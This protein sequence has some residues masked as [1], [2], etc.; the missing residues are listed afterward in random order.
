MPLLLSRDDVA[1]VLT[2][3]MC[4]AAVEG[5]F[6]A[7]ARGE[8]IMPQRAAMK[9][10]DHGGLFLGMP[11]YLAGGQEALGVKVVTVYPDNPQRHDLATTLGTLMLCDPATGAVS[12]IMDAGYLTAVRTGAASGVATRYLARQDARSCVVF[13]AGVQ[14]RQQLVAVHHV[15]P[16]EQVQVIDTS[17]DAAAA[18]ARDLGAELDLPIEPTDDAEAAVGAA[19]IVITASSSPTPL[20]KGAWLRPGTHINNIGSHAPTTRE[21]DTDAVVRSHYVADHRAASLAE[22]G[23]LLIPIAEGAVTAEHIQAE[24]GEVINGDAPGRTSADQITLFKS[25]GVAVQDMSTA[26]AVYDA[27][28]E[29]GL[30][31]EVRL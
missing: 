10:A 8:A 28:R 1:R 13:G 7:L 14:A 18:F 6:A 21:L 19:D 24:L 5:A 16:L 4:I 29:Q 2:M 15:R 12:A 27:A 30:G 11:A 31:T 22:A 25:C 26:R 20:L 3:P 23:D 9:V 17:T